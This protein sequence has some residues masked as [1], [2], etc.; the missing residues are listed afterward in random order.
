VHIWSWKNALAATY[1]KEDLPLLQVHLLDHH[2]ETIGFRETV[3]RVDRNDISPHSIVVLDPLP[4]SEQ[5]QAFIDQL[6]TPM[7]RYENPRKREDASSKDLVLIPAHAKRMKHDDLVSLFQATESKLGEAGLEV[8]TYSF[9]C[10]KYFWDQHQDELAISNRFEEGIRPLTE[11]IENN[12]GDTMRQEE[13]TLHDTNDWTKVDGRS[14]QHRAR[15]Q[16]DRQKQNTR[17]KWGRYCQQ[18][19]GCKWGHTVE[20]I[21]YARTYGAPKAYKYKTCRY[22]PC[23]KGKSCDYAHSKEELFCP[24]CEETGAHEVGGCVGSIA[25]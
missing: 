25:S 1:D 8:L 14:E 9:Y 5:I 16:R 3:F 20:Q 2:L 13:A 15:I 23:Y 4:K 19:P 10:Q 24:T 17:C 22:N 7:Y 21:K 11:T 6:K 18:L 12:T